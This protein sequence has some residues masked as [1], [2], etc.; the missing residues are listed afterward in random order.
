LAGI[1]S[2]NAA[3]LV[4]DMQRDFLLPEGYAA[5]AGL[6]IAPLRAA[7]APVA[8]VLGAA[9]AAGLLIVHTRE[10]HLPDLSD[11]PPYKLER[12]RRAGAEIGSKGPLGRLLVRGE[13]G[14][15]FVDELRPMTGEV[16][17][18]KPGYSAF[19]HTALQQ[20]LASRGIDALIVTGVTSEVC[21]SS[22]LRSATDRG[23]R[24]ITVRDACASADP[25]LHRAAMAMIE[26]EGGIFGEVTS[27][28]ALVK[29]LGTDPI[30]LK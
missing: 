25:T 6:D 11:C 22:T 8:A 7:I 5:K 2:R 9:R 3:L 13:F 10:G 15:D 21:V 4:I 16:V 29:K 1:L 30:I 26:V 20:L 19:E 14:H 12:S 27:A 17:I 24:C 28:A 23:Y 18:D